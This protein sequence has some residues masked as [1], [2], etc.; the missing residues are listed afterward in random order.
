MADTPTVAAG[1]QAVPAAQPQ[2]GTPQ[3]QAGEE[4]TVP[5]AGSEGEASI[6][7][8]AVLQ[9]E[10]AEARRE[11]ARYRSEAKKLT[12]AARVAD[13]AQLSEL[14]KANRRVAELERERDD[15]LTRDQERKLHVASVDTAARLGFRSP[16]LAVRLLDRAEVEFADDGSPK[17][18]E[19]LLKAVL[20][21][22]PYLAKAGAP[23]D[24][25]G[26]NR[27]ATPDTQHSMDELLRRA[28][29]G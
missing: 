16:E 15:L 3:P 21:R 4:P 10:L 25:G 28:A 9:R 23:G 12:D 7:D 20:E 14:E 11:A 26:G 5:A 22:E 24:F 1:A 13:E 2:A 8:P 17:N 19:P 29:R 6:V 18:I 27:G